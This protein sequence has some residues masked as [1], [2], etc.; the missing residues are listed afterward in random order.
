MYAHHKFIS[1]THVKMCF[2]TS[3]IQGEKEWKLVIHR[4]KGKANYLSEG[5][6]IIIQTWCELFFYS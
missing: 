2:H 6:I 4:A 3:E 5:G 1:R